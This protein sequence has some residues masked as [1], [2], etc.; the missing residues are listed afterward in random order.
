MTL[1]Q[2]VDLAAAK[3]VTVSDNPRL[4]AQL[5]VCHACNIEQVRLFA[6]PETPLSCTEESLFRSCFSSRLQGKPLAYISGQKEFWSLD[7][8]VNEDVLIP[9]PETELLV[10]IALQSIPEQKSLRILDLGTGSGA[11]AIAIAK[12]RSQCS[13]VATDFSKPALEVAQRNAERHGTEITFIHSNWYENLGSDRFDVIVS[14][15]PYVA[16][17]DPDLD[18]HV[19]EYEPAVALVS[20]T[21]GLE[22]LEMIISRSG[23][24]LTPCGW[25]VV[26]HGFTQGKDIRRLLHQNRLEQIRTCQDL[27]GLDR[28]SCA[29]LGSEGLQ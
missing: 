29:R 12:E 20:G 18:V 25:L 16:A 11:I 7:F 2:A 13:V 17:G 4:D 5:L 28:V 10:E 26:E 23:R 1:Q 14:N 24:H 21:S 8:S 3:L 22:A 15:P 27:S 6:H 9:R 19:K